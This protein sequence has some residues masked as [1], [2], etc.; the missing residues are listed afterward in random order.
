MKPKIKHTINCK[1]SPILVAAI[2]VIQHQ[3]GWPNR[4]LST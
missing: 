1:L 4:N 3:V 2:L